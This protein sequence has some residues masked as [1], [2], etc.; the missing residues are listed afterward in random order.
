LLYQMLVISTRRNQKYVY[1]FFSRTF[2][3]YV[4][5]IASCAQRNCK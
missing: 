1:A 3:T 4:H 5:I 2:T